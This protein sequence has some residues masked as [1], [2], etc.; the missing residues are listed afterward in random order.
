MQSTANSDSERDF[1][2][3]KRLKLIF[4]LVESISFLILIISGV[5]TLIDLIFYEKYFIFELFKTVSFN[6]MVIS[7]IIFFFGPFI[8]KF[9]ILSGEKFVQEIRLSKFKSDF[10]EKMK[11]V[12]EFDLEKISKDYDVTIETI[13]KLFEEYVK[14]GILRGKLEG[15]VFVLDTDF[16]IKPLYE[17]NL[18]IFEKSIVDYVKPFR[19][20]NIP[21]TAKNFDIKEADAAAIMS[22]LVK[23]G[24]IK[25]FIDGNNLIREMGLISVDLS[26][27]PECP[28]C[29]SKVLSNSKYCSNCGKKIDFDKI[30]N[31]NFE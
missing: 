11:D 8:L 16:E 23:D 26:D 14:T 9:I 7:A 5:I 19:W 1:Q 21:K 3:Y 17:K 4:I 6:T 27:L 15:N 10:V 12:R 13:R 20:L 25:G 22:R 18:E 30:L 2:S 31:D 28:H 24:K 29:D